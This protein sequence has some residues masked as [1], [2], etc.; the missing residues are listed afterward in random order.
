MDIKLAVNGTLM[1]GLPLNENLLQIGGRFVREAQTAACYRLWS[2]DGLYPGMVRVCQGGS[3]IALEIW[4]IPAHG[5]GQLLLQEPPGLS[6]GRILLAEGEEV[7]GIL[8]EPYLCEGQLDITAWGGGEPTSL[9]EIDRN[10][11]ISPA[12]PSRSFD[13]S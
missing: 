5:L 8:A 12:F 1:R 10:N 2:I 13:I 9:P 7:L 4:E 6:V 11:R 3:A